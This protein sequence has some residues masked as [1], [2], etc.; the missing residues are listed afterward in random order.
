MGESA[1]PPAVAVVNP[2]RLDEDSP[3]GHLAAV[4]VTF[5]FLVAL[6]QTLK[7]EGFFEAQ[8]EPNLLLLLDIVALGTVCDVVPLHGINRAFVSQGLKVLGRRMNMGLKVLS[9]VARLDE[10]P[11]PYHLGFILAPIS[12]PG[13]AW[14]S[15]IWGPNC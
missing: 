11:S 4:G 6:N 12:M 14:G 15:R 3:C 9:D 10:A 5:L 1:L 13:A 7:K 2:N 8:P